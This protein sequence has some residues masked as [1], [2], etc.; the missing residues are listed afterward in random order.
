MSAI[1]SD[2]ELAQDTILWIPRSNIDPDPDQVRTVFAGIDE[3]RDS[4]KAEGLKEIL[5]VRPHPADPDRFMLVSGERRWRATEK[6]VHVREGAPAY[7]LPCVLT[8]DEEGLDPADR[9]IS[10]YVSN[11]GAPLTPMDEARLFKT[12]EDEGVSQA[13]IARRLGV[14]RSSVGD[15][16]R[17]LDVH[18]SW[19]TLHDK[20]RLTV[21]HLVALAPYAPVPADE[22]VKAAERLTKDY[23]YT[24]SNDE[25]MQLA[26]FKRAI[27]EAFRPALHPLTVAPKGSH[28]YVGDGYCRFDPK[29]YDGVTITAPGVHGETRQKYAADP[30]VWGPLKRAA[31]KERK[32]NAPKQSHT[33]GS[34]RPPIDYEAERRKREEKAARILA[35][36]R[37]QFVAL[38]PRLPAAMD[39]AWWRAALGWIVDDMRHDRGLE[40]ACAVLG[41]EGAKGKYGAKDYAKPL[42]ARAESLDVAA[43]QQLT[44][45]ALLSSDL[46]VDEFRD[47]KQERL[48]TAAAL[49]GVSLEDIAPA[50]E[51]EPKKLGARARRRAKKEKSADVEVPVR[52]SD[53]AA[54]E[55]KAA[56]ERDLE[57]GYDASD[58]E[59]DDVGEEGDGFL[60][61]FEDEEE[62]ARA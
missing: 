42:R 45:A 18:E 50:A 20:G 59:L 2:A 26:A 52:V 10:Q 17:L 58:A 31:D 38:M 47:T 34:A 21:S 4:I 25:P 39:A 57:D 8:L 43:L 54:Q 28:R 29:L 62:E 53:D 56:A 19:L 9:L 60:A 16:I 15:R 46:V 1:I 27:A 13:E 49:L 22:Q 14:P 36:R 5:R 32:A 30:T 11:T 55:I 23:H 44:L 61:A 35:T 40:H 3:L 24:Q 41:I 6:L 51:E 48:I 33:A 37:A 12:L 7:C